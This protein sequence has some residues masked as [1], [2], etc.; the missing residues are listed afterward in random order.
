[1]PNLPGLPSLMPHQNKTLTR[2]EISEGAGVL[3][4][5]TGG[6][7]T[8]VC[9]TD[10][11]NLLMEGKIKR[12][13]VVAP[14]TVVPEWIREIN[15]ISQGEINAFP[16]RTSVYNQNKEVGFDDEYWVKILQGL[17]PNTIVVTDYPFLIAR[18][19]KIP[20]LNNIVTRFP[21]AELLLKA[22][23]DYLAVDESHTI[24]NQEAQTTQAVYIVSQKAK[25]IRLVSGTTI[26]DKPSDLVGQI[27]LINPF[28]LGNKQRFIKEHGIGDSG[29][30]WDTTTAP[31]LYRKLRPYLRHFMVKKDEWAYL[32]PNIEEEFHTVEMTERQ[33]EYYRAILTEIQDKI[34]NDKK[35]KAIIAKG[36]TDMEDLLEK[37]LRFHISRLEIFINSPDSVEV[38]TN[39]DDLSTEDLISSKVA[40]VDELIEQH[41]KYYKK[42]SDSF[43]NN[44]KII[45]FGYNKEVSKH[46]LK[47]SR[48]SRYALHFQA[49]DKLALNRFRTDPRVQILIGDEEGMNTGINLQVASMM[50]RLQTLWSPG[51][52]EQALA[53]MFRPD[54]RGRYKREK[55]NYHW[56]AMNNSVEI[57]KTARFISKTIVKACFDW[58]DNPDFRS[59][60]E[61]LQQLPIIRINPDN[62][63]DYNNWQQLTSSMQ[64]VNFFHNYSLVKAWEDQQSN[65]SLIQ[66]KTEI[67]KITGKTIKN[68]DDIAQYVMVP[69]ESDFKL[70][71]SR[72]HYVP[73]IDNITPVDTPSLDLVPVSSVEDSGEEVSNIDMKFG[74]FVLTEYGPGEVQRITSKSIWV[75][76]RGFRSVQ[77][78][79]Y[80]VYVPTNKKETK[81]FKKEMRK[82]K[83][84]PKLSMG[85]RSSTE[86]FDI[87]ESLRNK[88]PRDRH[89]ENQRKPTKPNNIL[90][91]DHNDPDT[92][93]A[94]YLHV[95]VI[96]GLLMVFTDKADKDAAKIMPK[97]GYNL[98]DDAYYQTVRNRKALRAYM[99]HL[100]ALYQDEKI[101]LGE[102]YWEDMKRVDKLWKSRDNLG[103]IKRTDLQK[104]KLDFFRSSHK[105]LKN[106]STIRPFTLI[107][108]NEV[109]ILYNVRVHKDKA[110][111]MRNLNGVSGVTKINDR[112]IFKAAYIKFVDSAKAAIKELKA[113]KKKGIMVQNEV[114]FNESL[115]NIKV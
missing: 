47:H 92:V 41:F 4:I 85:K 28:P 74:D 90:P 72:G 66:M 99:M 42:K 105:P 62:I 58:E 37:A 18:S 14:S 63:T 20:Y 84:L 46:I 10:A 6:G 100:D 38:F 40:K 49:G 81:A 48:F 22:G 79:K 106:T 33:I 39:L 52:Q 69:L 24:K 94:L 88:T 111:L 30:A 107:W 12:V 21:N 80:N 53:R 70:P 44:H 65:K 93:D 60:A 83:G 15:T 7:K 89:E 104:V 61:K 109:R 1:M 86:Y 29:H 2:L 51:K 102:K 17:P 77:L 87:E 75:G 95:A 35:I 56:I 26:S 55:V 112:A 31:S 113:V 98:T 110:F 5:D 13:L 82:F 73:W 64:G 16:L 96:N 68:K 97:M 23:F 27:G 9:I 76:V 25:F 50:I 34:R 36:G 115:E 11:L 59:L 8:I 43:D 19:Q 101:N 54:P 91:Q 103:K 57:T 108:N 32:L 3:S 114:E 78:P 71:N 67:E 45:V